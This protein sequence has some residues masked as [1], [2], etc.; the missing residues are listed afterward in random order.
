MVKKFFRGLGYVISAALLVL[1][2]LLIVAAAAF[3]SK[4]TVGAFGMNIFLVQSENIT[5]APKDSAVIVKKCSVHDL[6]EGNLIMYLSDDE[7]R[8]AALAYVKNIYP[9]D[10]T[11]FVTVTLDNKDT[12]IPDASIVGRADYSS[13]VLGRM[14][15]FIKT[16]L[17]VL[18]LAVLPCV[19]LIIYDILRAF[20][21]KLPPPEVIPQVKNA[22]GDSF[23]DEQVISAARHTGSKIAVSDDGKATYSRNRSA[24]K[25]GDAGDVL[26][27]YS[28]RQ[29]RKTEERPVIP[30]PLTD[31]KSDITK[32]TVKLPERPSSGYTSIINIGKADEPTAE[33]R[34]PSNVAVSRYAQNSEE[35]TAEPRRPAAS[36]TA[37]LP[38]IPKRDSGDAFFAQTDA[39]TFNEDALKRANSAASRAPQ[40]DRSESGIVTGRTAR[41]ARKRSTQ[42]IA[43]KGLDDLL[44]D[45]DDMLSGAG[46]RK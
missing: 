11:Y 29:Q 36:K 38:N 25:A 19:A 33:P 5:T 7:E 13:L 23:E 14:I 3:G 12:V 35:I 46:R 26:F 40:R 21:A 28:G 24:K 8:S 44:S 4:D 6:R 45:D 16:P 43:S 37:E 15:S 9:N 2:V 18:F 17:G 1:C 22:D 41:T 42:I 20:A 34:T 10:G 32:P 30:I 39:P 31:K 27:N